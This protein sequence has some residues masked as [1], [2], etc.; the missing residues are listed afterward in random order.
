MPSVSSLSLS[1]SLSCSVAHS[2]RYRRKVF[3]M[4][5]K[6]RFFF[7]GEYD[8]DDDD[9][10]NNGDGFARKKKKKDTKGRDDDD[11]KAKE[12]KGKGKGKDSADDAK[13]HNALLAIDIERLSD[14]SYNNNNNNAKKG[15]IEQ[16]DGVES[17]D[18]YTIAVN[19]EG[20]TGDVTVTVTTSS[21]QRGNETL[22][23]HWIAAY[24]PARADVKAIAPI[25]YAILNTVSKGRY[26]EEGVAEVRFKLTSVRE[27]TYDFVLFGDSWRWKHYNRAEV[28][29]RSEAI[30]LVGYLEPA[31]PRVV[32]VKTPSSLS[33]SSSSSGLIRRVAITWNSGRDASSTPRIEWRTNTNETSSTNW[34]QVVATKTETYSREDLCHAPA[35]T[36][37]FRSPGY[38]HTSI[39]YDVDVNLA[40]RA[41]AFE[42]IEY[43]LVDDATEPEKQE[44]YCCVYK[45]ILQ[46]NQDTRSQQ[47]PSSSSTTR[48]TELLFFGDMAR[49]SVDDA[50]TWHI[51]GSPAWN[52]SDSI[53]RHV[54]VVNKNSSSKVQGVFLFGDLSYAKGYA[55]VWD[56]FLAQITPWAS[57]IPLLTNQ[58]NHEYDTEVEFWPETRKGFEDLY[59]GN[60]SGGECGVAATVLF[61]TPRDDKETIGADSDWFKTEIGLISIVSMNTEA[62]FKVGSR[63]YVFLERALKNI[64][65]TRTPWVIVTGHRPGLVDS[66]EKPDPDDHESNRIESTDIGV[67]N[68]IQDHL[69]ENLFLKFNVDLTFWGHHHVYQRSCSW[70]KFNASSDQIH[71]TEVFGI[72]RTNG[73]VQYS[74]ANNIYSNPK[75]PISLVVG[76]G[77]ASLVKQLSRPKS[78]FNEITLYTHGYIDLVA[79]NST[80]LHCKF[81]DGIGENTVLD[82]FVILRT[83]NDARYENLLKIGFASVVLLIT[84]LA[85]AITYRFFHPRSNSSSSSSS[86]SR[87][88]PFG[89]PGGFTKLVDNEEEQEEQKEEIEEE[90]IEMGQIEKVYI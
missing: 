26:V 21:E 10:E 8:D 63:Q 15:G 25:K 56:E 68:M 75:A 31:H 84:Y 65:R 22:R 54:N 44:I 13:R 9:D 42:A 7:P 43:R 76:T 74:D 79:H 30:N 52:V 57:Q 77:G 40:M 53:A 19:A 32:L 20:N 14:E 47:Q 18:T 5:L 85:F 38:V 49:G 89:G 24:S 78:V 28:F 51:S 83:D 69:W 66:D 3:L 60:D 34:K 4:M 70:E 36:Y 41:N 58:G 27:E 73:C 16:E 72:G 35:T 62:D 46:A 6:S 45:P 23:S 59:G 17:D 50:E 90:E 80:S 71:P 39:L 64:D 48:E 67:M 12:R 11:G 82:E 55:S 29:A 2:K 88:R 86:R 61:P 37:G 33:S 87:L 1:L 81:I